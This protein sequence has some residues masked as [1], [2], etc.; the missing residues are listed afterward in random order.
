MFSL[1]KDGGFRMKKILALIM[2]LI[3]IVCMIPV[4]GGNVFAK[5]DSVIGQDAEVGE[6][7]YIGTYPQSRVDNEDLIMRLNALDA[8]ENSD[9]TYNGEKYRYKLQ[10]D[11]K[12]WY[13]YDPIEW[14]VLEKSEKEAFLVT[15]KIIDSHPYK[16]QYP[17]SAAWAESDARQWVNDEFYSVAFSENEKNNIYTSNVI[18]NRG[19]NTTDKI[20]YLSVNE[21]N[22]T[23]LGLGNNESRIASGTEYCGANTYYSRDTRTFAITFAYGVYAWN[24]TIQSYVYMYAD[25]GARPCMRAN[26]SNIPSSKEDIDDNITWNFDQSTKTLYINGTGKIADYSK[27]DSAPWHQHQNEAES[28]VVSEGITRIGDYA[29]DTFRNVTE[30]NLPESLKRIGDNSFSNCMKLEAITIPEK[31]SEIGEG[32]FWHCISLDDVYFEGSAPLMGENMFYDASLNAWYVAADKTWTPSVRKNYGGV[33][34]WRIWFGKREPGTLYIDSMN[35]GDIT[36]NTSGYGYSWYT[37]TDYRGVPITD[38]EVSWTFSSGD[39]GTTRTNEE[40]AFAVRTPEVFYSEFTGEF[41]GVPTK[42][43]E[44]DIQVESSFPVNG[45]SQN[46]TIYV[47]G[48]VFSQEW[49][50]EKAVSGGGDAGIISAEATIGRDINVSYDAGM[51]HDSLLIQESIS[52][53]AG[54]SGG[55]SVEDTLKNTLGNEY[56][57]KIKVST[58]GSNTSGLT[59]GL[60]IEDYN[61]KDGEQAVSI[62]ANVLGAKFAGRL[63]G[64]RLFQALGA[65]AGTYTNYLGYHIASSLSVGD[66]VKFSNGKKNS[67]ALY[68]LG[69]QT[70]YNN[71]TTL[72][73]GNNELDH[74]V[75]VDT[76]KDISILGLDKIKTSV[77][78]SGTS[79]KVSVNVKEHTDGT[80]ELSSTLTDGKSGAFLVA[81]EKNTKSRTLVLEEDVADELMKKNDIW[82]SFGAFDMDLMDSSQ[83]GDATKSIWSNDGN[84]II[85]DNK[86]KTISIPVEIPILSNGILGVNI[87]TAFENKTSYS[88][89]TSA[90]FEGKEYVLSES[91]ITAT[92]INN[93][94]KSITDIVTDAFDTA[95]N[96]IADCLT[97]GW[98]KASDNINVGKAT[99]SGESVPFFVE[100][101]SVKKEE[102]SSARNISMATVMAADTENE[103][104]SVAVTIGEPYYIQV[105]EDE[106]KE[107]MIT[108]DMLADKS[109]TISLSYTD[110]LNETG[111]TEENDICL[112]YFDEE[113]GAYCCLD[114]SQID[115]EKDIVT[116]S[117]VHNGEY[118]LAVDIAA[119][120]VTDMRLSNNT[121]TPTFFA[122]ITDMNGIKTFSFKLD[123]AEIVNEKNLKGYYNLESGEFKY[124]FE[125]LTDG[126]H[127]ITI[128]AEDGKGNKTAEDYIFSFVTDTRK[129]VLSDLSVSKPVF[130]ENESMTVSMTATDDQKMDAV[131]FEISDSIGNTYRGEMFSE[132]DKNWN[133]T[134]DGKGLSG[135]YKIR[136]FAIDEAGNITAM[137]TYET[138]KILPEGSS[139]LEIKNMSADAAGF[140]AVVKN[141][142]I[143]Q[144]KPI[145][146][147][148]AYDINGKVI[149]SVNTKI[150]VDAEKEQIV[151]M[152]L[153][154]NDSAAAWYEAYIIEDNTVYQY[155]T[156]NIMQ[157]PVVAVPEESTVMGILPDNQ[158]QINLVDDGNS[159]VHLK[160]DENYA[161]V[162]VNGYHK[163]TDQ[164]NISSLQES[165]LW[166]LSRQ[167]VKLDDKTAVNFG[168]IRLDNKNGITFYLIGDDEIQ[169]I[170]AFEKPETPPEEENTEQ[171]PDDSAEE[172]SDSSSETTSSEEATD[173]EPFFPGNGTVQNPENNST[174]SGLPDKMISLRLSALSNK[175][176]AGKRVQLTA[177]IFPVN[178]S[179]QRLIWSSSNPKVATVNQSGI[180]TMKKKTGGKSVII[181]ARVADG[182]GATATFRIKSMKGVVKK[183]TIAGAKKRIVKAGQKLKLKAKVTATK[184]ANKKLIWTSSNTKYAT[185]SAS[186]KVK[187]KKLGRGKKV[188]IT[189]MA[190]DGSNKKMTVTIKLK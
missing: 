103:S 149:D 1:L 163:N 32:A 157:E 29:F 118:I 178:A 175:I 155:A 154:L 120:L 116:A 161:L 182:S 164:V 137:D 78:S 160:N 61:A 63:W 135:Q 110:I 181:T 73:M 12:K 122:N 84:G 159:A 152:N 111:I 180:V 40:G 16:S 37:L 52:G 143:Y 171:K 55:A 113:K 59:G 96:T 62:A 81:S 109:L 141:N 187:T 2:T 74:S 77:L 68:S 10:D 112:Y 31:V 125:N 179:D 33:V 127:V 162:A 65:E 53:T 17:S 131:Y 99:V 124:S 91:T 146:F 64:E 9:V 144:C 19:E 138:V 14:I 188:K 30:V 8:D 107:N 145:V 50:E 69:G 98:G 166:T 24:G 108:D 86:E 45:T 142:G 44:V 42:K 47:T 139:V 38:T 21:L 126:N 101:N 147:C 79:G 93:N 185:V 134:V 176:A 128:S 3:L 140:S 76:E 130:H 6:S 114:D 90:W 172:G 184:G 121:A 186:G 66:S 102:T 158:F 168:E 70:Q 22:D 56:A 148:S 87:K 117:L 169:Y 133:G 97:M 189:A 72:N 4:Y 58:G 94:K 36:V 104:P 7:V 92:Q 34:M 46:F 105:Y 18:N 177:D 49:T 100:I 183:V 25:W 27:Q 60:Y 174:E 119:P 165:V 15:K 39:S 48:P 151:N 106:N 156:L 115:R 95:G 71:E 75:S 150:T 57:S 167:A 123:D 43:F 88:D 67:I 173:S 82:K 80:K 83:I 153:T 20:Y 5:Q 51:E 41:E 89:K 28:I 54:A 170:T 85:K 136:A 26:I 190:T 13:K 23:N 35:L 11:E 129:P 132:N